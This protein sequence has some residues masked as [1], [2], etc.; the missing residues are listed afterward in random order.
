MVR[1]FTYKQA[2]EE[3]VTDN[4]VYFDLISERGNK[5]DRERTVLQ[6]DSA[7]CY[8]NTLL[9]LI[10]PFLSIVHKIEIVRFIHT[11]TQ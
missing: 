6:S 3:E 1:Y 2:E 8:Q 7:T 5:Q 10:L 11:E 9:P 4:K